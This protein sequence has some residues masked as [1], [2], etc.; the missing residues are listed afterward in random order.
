MSSTL[1]PQGFPTNGFVLFASNGFLRFSLDLHFPIG[2]HQSRTLLLIDGHQFCEQCT[3]P[4]ED[5]VE[6]SAIFV[7]LRPLSDL[8]PSL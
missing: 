5:S 3:P 8:E 2:G 4:I 7:P 6:I 1:D